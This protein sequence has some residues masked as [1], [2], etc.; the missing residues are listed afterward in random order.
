MGWKLKP[1]RLKIRCPF[2]NNNA[3]LLEKN[4]PGIYQIHF[5]IS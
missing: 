4:F 2:N 5:M 1:D 3:Y